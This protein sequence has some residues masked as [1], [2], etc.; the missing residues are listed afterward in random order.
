M[1]LGLKYLLSGR[2]WTLLQFFGLPIEN[3]S[4]R[5]NY[6]HMLIICQEH[7][8]GRDAFQWPPFC[9]IFLA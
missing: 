5:N 3:R 6:K 4:F 2:N 7:K 8:S 9:V 1:P